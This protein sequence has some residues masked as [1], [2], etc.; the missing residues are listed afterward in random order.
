MPLLSLLTRIQ[1]N[2][3]GRSGY[4]ASLEL[5]VESATIEE[6]FQV[7]RA[8]L[9]SSWWFLH[10][11][12]QSWMARVRLA[13]TEVFDEKKPTEILAFAAFVD[14]IRATMQNLNEK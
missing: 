14:L 4:L 9:G 2:L 1:L 6:T 8:Y 7:N 5:P 13:V 10:Q 3:L 11:G 12:W